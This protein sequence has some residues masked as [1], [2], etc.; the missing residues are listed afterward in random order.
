M[1]RIIR[2][3]LTVAITAVM[4][5][6]LYAAPALAA[7]PDP[8]TKALETVIDNLRTWII[9]ILAGVATLFATVGGARY[10]MAGGDPAE[11]EK[12]KSAIKSA[13]IGYALAILAPILLGV[14]QS[15]VGKG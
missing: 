6:A 15:I 12:A 13:L 8:N 10:L 9:I 4:A 11:I 14:L 5:V 1:F 3:G 7:G 2:R